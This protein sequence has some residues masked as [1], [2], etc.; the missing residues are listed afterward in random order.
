MVGDV[1]ESGMRRMEGMERTD[2]AAD[3]KPSL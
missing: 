2:M 1:E 3:I